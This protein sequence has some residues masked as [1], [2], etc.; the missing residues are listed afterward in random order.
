MPAERKARCSARVWLRD[1]GRCNFRRRQEWRT[2]LRWLDARSGESILDVG[3]G[4]GTYA[5]LVSRSGARVLGIDV[6][7]RR[8]PFAQRFRGG[9]RCAFV[10]MDAEEMALPAASFDKVMSLCVIEHF[11]RDEVVLGHVARVLRPG[12]RF[13][14]SADSLSNPGITDGERDRHRR[15]YAVNAFYT[16]ESVSAKLE[17]AGFAIEKTQYILHRRLD[18]ALARISW[19]LDDLPRGLGIARVLGV[20]L[21]WAAWVTALPFPGDEA[22]AQGGLTLLVQ[23]RKQ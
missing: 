1:L 5:E 7:P 21:I 6:H 17:R 13:V 12:G 18:L 22:R 8:L 14:F 10:H 16:K 3:C 2:A 4:D 20:I 19:R 9:G 11:G 15:R 23:A